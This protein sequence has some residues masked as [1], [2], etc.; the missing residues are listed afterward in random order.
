MTLKE[1]ND[2]ILADDLPRMKRLLDE[3]PALANLEDQ[4]GR[5]PIHMAAA[6][7]RVEITRLLIERG[8]EVNRHE[9]I[10]G[11]FPLLGAV[12]R[13][14]RDVVKLLLA[15]GANIHARNKEGTTALDLA[16]SL[17]LDHIANLLKQSGATP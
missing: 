11:T 2:L 16:T 12:S 5:A 6:H 1:I 17:G 15:N 14:H 9:F 3:N 10:Y 8:A 4:D 13:G 7:G